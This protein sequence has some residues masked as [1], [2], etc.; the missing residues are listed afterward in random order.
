MPTANKIDSNFSSLRYAEE[1]IDCIGHLPGETDPQGNP[2]PGTPNWVMLQPNSYNDFGGSPSLTTRNPIT[3]S[4]QLEK[5]VITDLEANAAFNIDFTEDNMTDLL[6]GFLYASW[7]NS[8][9]ADTVTDATATGFTGTGM[10]GFPVGT[11]VVPEGFN[12]NSG[13]FQ[14][15]ASDA[16]TVTT[17]PAPTVET[18]PAGSRLVRAGIAFATS[19]ISVTVDGGGVPSVTSATVDFNTHG[20]LAGSWVYVEGMADANNNGYARVSAI[21]A[22]GLSLILDKTMNTMTAAAG[23]GET[24]KIWTMNLLRNEDDASQIV[25][26][27]YQFERGL[28]SA[29]YEYVKGAVPNDLTLAIRQADPLRADLSFVALDTDPRDS[30]NRKPGTF[31]GLKSSIQAYNSANDFSRIRTAK[32]DSLQTPLFGFIMEMDLSIKNNVTPLKA[33]GTLGSFDVSIG[34]FMVEGSV[35]AYFSDIESVKAVRNNEDITLD[36]VLYKNNSAWV[37]DIPLVSFSDAKLQ[38]EKDQPIKLPVN[39][40]A[41]RDPSLGNTL[42]IGYFPYVPEP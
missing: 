25:M 30:A 28:G 13:P 40:N 4:R 36:F 38:V 16:T 37:F 19:D 17:T 22:D 14:V 29:G 3:S 41:A 39:M 31:P 5:G 33:I 9:E 12:L 32:Q 1:V 8:V 10:D 2:I 35:T 27:S 20:V 7:R 6:Q 34:D 21:S 15:T 11:L 18:A 24:V 42:T 26:R 23:T